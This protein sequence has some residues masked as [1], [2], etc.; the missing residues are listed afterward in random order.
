MGKGMSQGEREGERGGG[1]RGCWR[2]DTDAYKS[3]ASKAGTP[4]RW[5]AWD[6]SLLAGGGAVGPAWQWSTA[7]WL[8]NLGEDVFASHLHTGVSTCSSEPL[9]QV[10]DEG[11]PFLPLFHSPPVTHC[12]GDPAI[13]K[14]TLFPLQSSSGSDPPSRSRL[15]A[16]CVQPPTHISPPG[17]SCAATV[18]CHRE[19]P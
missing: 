5:P 1:R 11:L 3:Q 4:P 6:C 10:G 9:R 8:R 16:S 2:V 18:P 14:G 7:R 13:G 12:P 17:S 15:H 19:R